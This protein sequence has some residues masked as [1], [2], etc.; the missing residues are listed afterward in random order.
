MTDMVF[1]GVAAQPQ[2]EPILTR[3][4]RTVDKWT[5]AAVLALMVVGLVPT[6]APILK[7]GETR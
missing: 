7:S 1:G 2:S 5:V 6:N 4:W 3:W